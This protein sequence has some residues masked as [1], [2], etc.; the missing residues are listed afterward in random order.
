MDQGPAQSL[1]P[2]VQTP[3]AAHL[4]SAGIAPGQVAVDA[5]HGPPDNLAAYVLE[6][7]NAIA[8]G[9][10]LGGANE[11]EVHWPGKEYLRMREHLV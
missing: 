11:C 4:L 6:L 2:S 9:D 10:D 7:L 3:A 1:A 8:E 5:I